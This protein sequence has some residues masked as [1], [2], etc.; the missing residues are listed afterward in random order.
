[1]QSN[2]FFFQISKECLLT[3]FGCKCFFSHVIIHLHVKELSVLRLTFGIDGHCYNI[4][5]L[6]PEDPT[7]QDLIEAYELSL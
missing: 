4:A 5:V 6:W 2:N 1:M 3:R 7:I